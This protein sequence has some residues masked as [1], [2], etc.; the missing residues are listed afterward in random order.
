MQTDRGQARMYAQVD[1]R[2]ADGVIMVPHG[3]HGEGNC[4]LLTDCR[5]DSREPIMG[6]PTWKSQL[7]AV[8]PVEETTG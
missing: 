8:Q 5:A 3:W 4:N 1:D 7:C 2:I 6:Y